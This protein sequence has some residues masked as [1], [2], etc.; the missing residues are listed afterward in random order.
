MTY[1]R[2]VAK[3]FMTYNGK[4]YH[5]TFDGIE[6]NKLPYAD[7]KTL[8]E[9]GMDENY[10]GS[11]IGTGNSPEVYTARKIAVNKK[12]DGSVIKD[13]PYPNDLVSEAF[14]RV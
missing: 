11:A 3:D 2:H 5:K 7:K 12:K 9:R 10:A 14:G 1:N 6:G 8:S 4:V 13:N